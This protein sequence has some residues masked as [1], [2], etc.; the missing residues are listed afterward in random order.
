MYKRSRNKA[1]GWLLYARQGDERDDNAVF[2]R[3]I[4]NL[5]E[6]KKGLYSSELLYLYVEKCY[7]QFHGQGLSHD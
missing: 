3:D 5:A 4:Y 6:E 1:Y 2:A 7:H